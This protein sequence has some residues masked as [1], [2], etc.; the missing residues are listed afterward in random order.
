MDKIKEGMAEKVS[1]VIQ[2]GSM[3][4]GGLGVA[5]FHSWKVALVTLAISP[6]FVLATTLMFKVG[7]CELLF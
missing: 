5:L 6:V 7:F 4:I 3:A 2:Y 1:I